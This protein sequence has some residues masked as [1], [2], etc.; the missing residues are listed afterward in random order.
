MSRHHNAHTNEVQH[1]VADVKNMTSLQLLQTYNIEIWEGEEHNKIYDRT[2]DIVYQSA[3]EWANAAIEEDDDA[4]YPNTHKGG[5][6]MGG[7]DY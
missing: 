1:M 6:D 2:E 3:A 4:D 5:Y 7:E